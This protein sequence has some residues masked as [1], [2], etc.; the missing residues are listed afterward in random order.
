MA[1]IGL[2][3]NGPDK[4]ATDTMLMNWI[5]YYPTGSKRRKKPLFYSICQLN[6]ILIYEY[7][8]INLRL[9]K[10]LK[11]RIYLLPNL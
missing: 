11:C 8:N 4:V 1:K 9:K 10:E 6:T 5:C 7:E 2:L 3:Q